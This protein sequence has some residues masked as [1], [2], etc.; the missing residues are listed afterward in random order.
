[1]IQTALSTVVSAQNDEPYL[2]LSE[3]MLRLLLQPEEAVV[4]YPAQ[5]LDGNA[6]IVL[7]LVDPTPVLQAGYSRVYASLSM[8]GTLAAPSDGAEEMRYQVPLFGLPLGQTVARKYA[9]PFPLRNQRWIY[10]TDTCGTY[11]ERGLHL[12][13]YAE[14]IVGV[15]QATPGVTAVFFSSYSFLEQVRAAI[16]TSEQF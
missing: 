2:T 16:S 7:R 1:M 12:K 4:A 14:H 5:D 6:R 13:R 8:S 9:S 10:S 3:R 15:G 11:R